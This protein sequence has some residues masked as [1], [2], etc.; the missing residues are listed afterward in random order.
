MSWRMITVD[1]VPFRW[2]TGGSH[3]VIQNSEGQRVAD[4]TNASLF[5]ID[6]Q[7]YSPSENPVTPKIIADYIRGHLIHEGTS[8][9]S[10]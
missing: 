2:K 9:S 4:V 5:D 6:P 3:V 8:V 7:D 1:N 10:D